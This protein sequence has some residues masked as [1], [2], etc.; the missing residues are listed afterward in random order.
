MPRP[1]VHLGLEV[2]PNFR[3]PF[4]LDW[5]RVGGALE[6]SQGQGPRVLL[7]DS[8]SEDPKILDNDPVGTLSLEILVFGPKAS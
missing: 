8:Y 6:A 4:P 2:Y 3:P 1:R 5:A 7:L